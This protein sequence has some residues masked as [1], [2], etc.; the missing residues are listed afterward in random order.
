MKRKIKIGVVLNS[1]PVQSEPF[2]QE[3]INHLQDYEVILYARINGKTS[4][5]STLK[6]V[7]L[8]N[9][10]P[11][12]FLL[13][14]WIFTYLK[15]FIYFRRFI[16]LRKEH[17]PIKQLIADAGIWTTSRL[18]IL[19]YPF[20]NVAI[21]R[22]RYSGLLNAKMTLSFRGSDINVYPVYHNFNYSSMWKYVS[23]VHCNSRELYARLKLHSLPNSLPVVVIHPAIRTEI[24]NAVS[25]KTDFTKKNRTGNTLNLVTLGRLH[26]VKDYPLALRTVYLLKQKGYDVKYY[27]LGWGPELEHLIFLRQMYN[28]EGNVYFVGKASSELIFEYFS[29]ADVYLQTSLAEGFSNSCLEA[30]AFGVPCVVT[31]VSGMSECIKEGI[32]GLVVRFRDE[33]LLADAIQTVIKDNK[34]Y[35]PESISKRVLEEF[36]LSVQREKWVNFFD[37]L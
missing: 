19:H 23:A 30:Q 25:Q 1:Y 31:D 33:K 4:S 14:V 6:V 35:K 11:P 10:L 13:P 5:S 7:P 28:L 9:K 16:S 34:E 29:N 18:D 22:E 17:I 26:W 12:F 24:K 20:G 32:S 36:S 15:I 27:I 21:G 37:N 8:L 3:F 2:I